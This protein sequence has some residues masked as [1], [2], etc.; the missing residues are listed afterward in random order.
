MAHDDSNEFFRPPNDNAYEREELRTGPPLTYV[1]EKSRR[2]LES[3]HSLIREIQRRIPSS[4]SEELDSKG[5]PV[6]IKDEFLLPTAND[7]FRCG[8][9]AYLA[10]NN[11]LALANDGDLGERLLGYTRDEFG[12]WLGRIQ[13][14]GSVTG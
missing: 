8:L 13:R 12:D 3:L 9:T 4:L 10:L 5:N 7:A 2:C 14:E 6:S 11:M 1:A